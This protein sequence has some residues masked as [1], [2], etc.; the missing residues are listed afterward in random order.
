MPSPVRIALVGAGGMANTVHYPSLALFHDVELVGLCDLV[1]EK[2]AQTA[3]RF[4]IA[5]TYADYRQML[6]ETEPAAVYVL[7]PPH[8]LFDIAFDVM[9]RGLH[10]FL[11]KPPGVLTEQTRQMANC[12]EAHGCITMVGFN[13][14]YIPLMRQCRERV[15]SHGGGEM[16]QVVSSFYK[17][18]A[19]GPYY[20][21]ASDILTCDAIHAVDCLRFMGG[22]VTKV[23][24]QVGAQGMAFQTR[25]NALME[26]E[27]GAA[28]VLLANWRV[29]GRIHQFEMHA[30]GASA[31]VNP[32]T[33]ADLLFDG[34]EPAERITTH[35][36][37]GSEEFRVFYGFEAE[38]RAF[39]DAILSGTQPETCLADAVKTMELADRLSHNCL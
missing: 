2:L 20:N 29:G 6:D 14:R 17:W 16:L 35:E 12:A 8:Q 36:A 24:G 3:E 28:G 25:F 37:S 13:R 26:F 31:Y 4:G 23:V 7:M 22:E 5:R 9:S 38:N 32:N 11:E 15:L 10:L 19:A 21:G 27:S 39:V 30:C 33:H 18:H 34:A 1:P